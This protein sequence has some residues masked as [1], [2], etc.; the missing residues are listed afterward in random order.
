M[1]PPTGDD[2]LAAARAGDGR[3]FEALAAYRSDAAGVYRADSVHVV[4]V[5]AE[6]EVARVV[7]FLGAGA[8]RACDG[9][10]VLEGG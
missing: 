10:E 7:A 9:A 5:S 1:N 8:V 4:T 3:A 2:T 6:G